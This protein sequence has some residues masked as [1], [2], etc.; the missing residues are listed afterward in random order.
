MAKAPP[1]Y[2]VEIDANELLADLVEEAAS[3]AEEYEEKRRWWM[4]SLDHCDEWHEARYWMREARGGQRAY[5]EAI[6]ALQPES[7]ALVVDCHRNEDGTVDV[8]EYMAWLSKCATEAH[9]RSGSVPGQNPQADEAESAYT[10][11]LSTIRDDYGVGWPRLDDL[12]GNPLECDL[13]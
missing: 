10:R 5:S 2:G 8:R 13:P 11:I 4:E 3:Y 9:E 12:G 7:H 1:D 6:A